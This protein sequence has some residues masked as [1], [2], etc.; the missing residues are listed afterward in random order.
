MTTLNRTRR[1]TDLLRARNGRPFAT[2]G[3]R[4]LTVLLNAKAGA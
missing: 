1:L 2:F 4:W 3:Y